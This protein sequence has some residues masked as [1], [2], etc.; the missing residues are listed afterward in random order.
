[1]PEKIAQGK[2]GGYCPV[3][4]TAAQ[5]RAARALL[6][7]KQSDLA[8]RA[9]IGLSTIQDFEAGRHSPY[10]RTLDRIVRTFADAG[11]EFTN[12]D[13]PGV[14]LVRDGNRP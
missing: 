5:C 3:M 14:R 11:V 9:G 6:D 2:T 10:Q 13:A 4:I 1:M 12:G 7:W 8:E